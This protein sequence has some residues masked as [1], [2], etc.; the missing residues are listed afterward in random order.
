[1]AGV[2]ETP[3][4]KLHQLLTVINLLFL[5]VSVCILTYK[6]Y[7]LDTLLAAKASEENLSR[8]RSDHDDLLAR[9]ESLQNRPHNSLHEERRLSRT[10]RHA[11]SSHC[12]LPSVFL[13]RRI[14]GKIVQVFKMKKVQTSPPCVTC[15]CSFDF[16]LGLFVSAEC[17]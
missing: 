7:R 14:K 1:M 2:K 9:V 11:T 8:L 6:V 3:S 4:T 13:L 16:H 5:V 10:K 12:C 15:V 17:Y